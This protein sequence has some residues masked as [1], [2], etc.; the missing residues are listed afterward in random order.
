MA[1]GKPARLRVAGRPGR[2]DQAPT[3]GIAL[4]LG[5]DPGQLIVEGGPAL[6]VMNRKMPPKIAVSARHEALLVGP[7]IPKLALMLV[8][9][10]NLGLTR[11]EPQI[12]D[13]DIFPGNLLRG[14]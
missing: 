13:Y 1:G 4:Q 2:D 3:H 6:L 10:P 8:K 11:K 7:G 5:Q 12:L 14:E 9:E